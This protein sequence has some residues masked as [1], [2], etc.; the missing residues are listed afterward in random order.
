MG[1]ASCPLPRNV[2]ALSFRKFVVLL[3]LISISALVGC[4]PAST[5]PIFV[6][7]DLVASNKSYVVIY[8]VPASFG[9]W[10]K[11]TIHVNKKA[12]TVLPNGGYYVYEADAPGNLQFIAVRQ[13]LPIMMIDRGFQIADDKKRILLDLKVEG[14]RIYYYRLNCSSNMYNSMQVVSEEVGQK[15]LETLHRADPAQGEL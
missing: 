9:R 13:F 6:K 15:E 7:P 14:G 5:G 12:I 11:F 3:V 10:N 2:F 1:N 8:R 4:A